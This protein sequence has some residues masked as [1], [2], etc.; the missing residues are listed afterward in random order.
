MTGKELV[1]KTI[2]FEQPQRL[3]YDLP[4][5]YGTDFMTISISPS[6]D[7]RL[8]NGVDEWGTV[9]GNV[10]ASK[11]GKVKEYPLKDWRDFDK[12]NIPDIHS[13]N[14]WMALEGAREK[15]GE[16]FLLGSG[17]SIYERI[18]F[19]R[20][21]ENAWMDIIEAPEQLC[22]LI[23]IIV[24]MNLAV[25]KRY[26]EAGVDGLMLFDDWGLQNR[27]MISPDS[28]RRIWRPRY[29]RICQTA[30]KYGLFTFLHSCGYIVD[31]LDD[32]IEAG[33]DVIQM[34]QQENMGLELLGRRFSGRITFYNPV[35]I[36]TVMTCGTTDEIRSYCRRMV[37]LLGT[38][39]GGF[40]PK[41][42]NDPAGAG[43]RQEALDA[44]CEEFLK[45]C[46]S[47][48]TCGRAK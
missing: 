1:A 25:I 14:R 4:E 20:G 37:K 10:G 30:H 18:H 31:I 46:Y 12:L 3:P 15:A 22:R 48:N 47:Y 44:M 16:K 28:W 40:I 45:L 21:F 5:K 17:I 29:E 2:R 33:L 19:I 11:L 39:K 7:D 27:L 43:H 26:A 35:D 32:L 13:P 38:A 8:S 23:D 9:W 41:W 42:Y 6:P 24:E 36:Q 34:D